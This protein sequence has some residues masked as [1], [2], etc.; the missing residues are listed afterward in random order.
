MTTDTTTRRY[1]GNART[2][3]GGAAAVIAAGCEI[4]SQI[5][6]T[7]STSDTTPAQRRP[8]ANGP[9]SS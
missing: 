7:P 4:S 1:T 5:E 6:T 2:T 9:T 3:S 8:G